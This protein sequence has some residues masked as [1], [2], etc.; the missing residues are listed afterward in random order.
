MGWR[1]CS[2][3]QYTYTTYC[4]YICIYIYILEYT[5]ICI[6]Y[7]KYLVYMSDSR[8]I[9]YIQ[10]NMHNTY[11]DMCI[12]IYRYICIYV[13]FIYRKRHNMDMMHICIY[14]Y[15]NI[16]YTIHALYAVCN[17]IG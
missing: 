9:V 16:Y 15:I 10:N 5:Y 8:C 13:L 4:V 6:S 12:Y 14:I 11:S 7:I 2:A 1:Q 3:H 17:I